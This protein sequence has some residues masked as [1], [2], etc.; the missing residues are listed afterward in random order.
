M[1]P[2]QAQK[3]H[4]RWVDRAA[5]KWVLK[6]HLPPL[7]PKSAKCQNSRKNPNFIL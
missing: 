2:I 3:L 7:T 1:K 4:V 6:G 5:I